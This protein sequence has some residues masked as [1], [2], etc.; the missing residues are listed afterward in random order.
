MPSLRMLFFVSSPPEY[1][2]RTNPDA[3]FDSPSRIPLV[4]GK[5]D[6]INEP[7]PFRPREFESCWEMNFVPTD[8]R[9]SPP[10]EGMAKVR[11][12]LGLWSPNGDLGFPAGHNS[13]LTPN[14][15]SSLRA[16]RF[17]RHPCHASGM[18]EKY[19]YPKNPPL[20]VTP[21]ILLTI[22]KHI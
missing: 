1:K 22:E 20:T 14:A 16:S 4:C 17:I 15:S 19:F 3:N 6:S 12:G 8:T 13:S 2:S 11:D 18:I 10:L 7:S 5:T 9:L 21:N